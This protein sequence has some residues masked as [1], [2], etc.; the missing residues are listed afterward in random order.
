MTSGVDIRVGLQSD[1]PL[2]KVRG[3]L[4][5]IQKT[6][7][8]L[9][10]SFASYTRNVKGLVKEL[11]TISRNGAPGQSVRDLQLI[12]GGTTLKGR[13]N[14][15]AMKGQIADTRQIEQALAASFINAQRDILRN[16]AKSVQ[17]SLVTDYAKQRQELA[18]MNTNLKAQIE[19]QQARVAFASQI[20]GTRGTNRAR[21]VQNG[22]NMGLSNIGSLKEEKAAL[23]NLLRAEKALTEENAKQLRD[24][25]ALLGV[26]ERLKRLTDER[27]AT[28]RNQSRALGL[29]QSMAT[30]D[31][32]AINAS[33]TGDRMGVLNANAKKETLR[34]EQMILQGVREESTE[35]QKQLGVIRG[36]A[37]EREKIRVSGQENLRQTR[38]QTRLQ[39]SEDFKNGIGTG[40]Q[41]AVNNMIGGR[42]AAATDE[43]RASLLGLQGNLL[44]NYALIGSVTGALTGM[45][46]AVIE[47]DAQ[48]RQLQAI[49]GATNAEYMQLKNT[50]VET[51]ENTKFSAV[52]LAEGATLLAQ[53]GLSAQQIGEILPTV[54]NFA[55]AVGT[56][57]KTAGDIITT[58]LTV[59]N[60]ASDETLR[61]TNVLTEALNRSKLSMEQ[62]TLGFQ[63]AANITA[64]AGGTFEEL[65]AVLAGMSQAGIRSGSMLGTGLRQIMISLASPTEEVSDLLKQLG[66]S[67]DDVDVRTQG[68]VG[69]LQ[70]F[71]DAGITASQAMGA[72]ETRTAA[73]L[74]AAT[75]Q[76]GFMRNLQEQMIYTNAAEEAA[77]VQKDSLKNSMLELRNSFLSF[78]QD[79]AA[80]VVGMLVQLAQ[81]VKGLGEQLGPLAGLL[82]P[83]GTL[84][85]LFVGAAGIAS[86]AR[87]T[88]AFLT[89]S[90]VL[91]P[92]RG[93]MV[94]LTASMNLYM[95]T[96][97]NVAK[98]EG[99]AAA[100]AWGLRAALTALVTHPVVLTLAAIVGV[101]GVLTNGFGM[102]SN[103]ADQHRA[104][105]DELRTAYD[106]TQSRMTNYNEVLGQIEGTLSR[107]SSRSTTLQGDQ[108]ALK[109][110]VMNAAVQFNQYGASIRG[111]S[112]DLDQLTGALYR[113]RQGVLDLMY[114]EAQRAGN[115]AQLAA[116][117]ASTNLIGGARAVTGGNMGTRFA[118]ANR[119]GTGLYV[120]QR[121]FIAMAEKEFRAGRISR[122]QFVSLGRDFG[123]IQGVGRR[124]GG[125][126]GELGIQ[127]S[128]AAS[129]L[130]RFFTNA[131]QNTD[132]RRDRDR[133]TNLATRYGDVGG[134][135]Y[136]V[137]SQN[138][139]LRTARAQE[140]ELGIRRT[141]GFQALER[142]AA[143]TVNVN[144]T[145]I[146][147]TAA[148][149]NK[150]L[151]LI[152]TQLRTGMRPDGSRYTAADATRDRTALFARGRE[153]LAAGQAG[154]DRLRLAAANSSDPNFI[155]AA[156]TTLSGQAT[157]ASSELAGALRSRGS[158]M[159]ESNLKTFSDFEAALRPANADVAGVRAAAAAQGIDFG[160]ATDRM[161]MLRYSQTQKAAI[162]SGYSQDQRLGINDPMTA[163]R[164][165]T[166]RLAENVGGGGGGGGGAGNAAEKAAKDAKR[167]NDAAAS[168]FKRLSD[169]A[170]KSADL[171]L[172]DLDEYSTPEQM[173][174]VMAE[175][176]ESFAAAEQYQA[177]HY[178]T[179]LEGLKEY[180]DAL[181]GAGAIT[182]S[183]L[184]DLNAEILNTELEME[185]ATQNQ[186]E[187]INDKLMK[188]LER[189]PS[190]GKPFSSMLDTIDRT[191]AALEIELM[192]AL[193]ELDQLTSSREASGK[194]LG[195]LQRQGRVAGSVTSAYD[196]RYARDI[197][198]AELGSMGDRLGNLRGRQAALG[199]ALS[200]GVTINGQEIPLEQIDRLVTTQ[201]E[202]MRLLEVGTDEY[203]IQ[204]LRL[205]DLEGV[206]ERVNAF[207]KEELDVQKEINALTQAQTDM[208]AIQ[209][210]SPMDQAKL[211]GGEWLE[212]NGF[213]KDPITSMLEGLPDVLTAAK[214]GFDGFFTS[215]ATG[216]SSVG[217]AFK[218]LAATI[219]D[220]ML[221]VVVSELTKSFLK[222][223][224]S[225]AG[226]LGGGGGQ[227]GP[228][229]E[230]AGLYREGGLIR[231][232]SGYGVTGRDS[233]P[234]LAM[235]GEYVLRKS[236]V[237]AI[238][239]KSLD[240]I[241]AQGNRA[242]S[243]QRAVQP[244]TMQ[245]QQGGQPL[246]IYV[247]SPD[248][249]PPPS[250]D[251]II[252]MI[253]DDMINRGPVYKTTR[254]IQQGAI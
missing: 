86:L 116:S 143:P 8:L 161:G 91:A 88:G 79:A 107:L 236:A 221:S 119:S 149:F 18:Q 185:E 104:K 169:A 171:V 21:L 43:G 164:Y 209:A 92:I 148:T 140:G 196:A 218:N 158:A 75:N 26:E 65:T 29:N 191:L 6:L 138:N 205:K 22:N 95:F 44:M 61:I 250:R 96:L 117:A 68:L 207:K 162:E 152:E 84:L 52:E 110:E 101:V 80:P 225:L 66:L 201:R 137:A 198:S 97:I 111:T 241:N 166:A 178:E 182:Q 222:L 89:F 234:I 105:M 217:D 56:D 35:Y 13:V 210:M 157:A 85:M 125:V 165:G 19:A 145:P 227:P 242:V 112:I 102:L 93:M 144:G 45:T 251:E 131:A 28:I 219:L 121:Q 220:A 51:S 72:F 141:P 238:G 31:V 42:R 17:S 206:Q 76:V 142:G 194:F 94:G 192:E 74:I 190:I 188:A 50:V 47:L 40:R 58:T 156:N 33:A 239:M 78:I 82:A 163:L 215:V 20:D 123:T 195:I 249:T 187:E 136:E 100:G 4:S 133:L 147:F 168:S 180:R 73:A 128:M 55:M 9:N 64:D 77:R 224:L 248:K 177:Q 59:F 232:A 237:D 167:L 30:Q 24:S 49:S 179:K 223:V 229:A 99:V 213:N 127:S 11:D 176:Q 199:N 228:G 32:R 226:S 118:E 252:V 253:Q 204:A 146:S 57:F 120:T 46:T 181:I 130:T 126:D 10:G 3:S 27:F 132:N 34:L 98:A 62:L 214:Q 83:L 71:A 247:V 244:I 160:G 41:T 15:A 38:E 151:A 230:F 108:Q 25:R 155:S 154:Q 115:A 231:A 7:D 202:A 114:A 54:S 235:P 109:I 36:I 189:I 254:A 70:N 37:Q 174:A 240:Q 183:E 2:N 39:Q 211:V 186:K 87:L 60:M 124:S 203:A 1:E 184:S 153:A 208:A 5:E 173:E 170:S 139:I 106:D 90:G 172:K 14:Q 243:G 193:R 53:A 197:D 122:E 233:V 81:G 175:A 134:S 245:G 67:M 129:N 16:V 246:N 159:D 12:S 216:A 48:M 212:A 63:Y 69:V 113:A 150:D 23:D 135:S 103:G 200:S